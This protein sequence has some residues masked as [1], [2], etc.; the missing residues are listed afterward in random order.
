MTCT[1]DTRPKR[2]LSAKLAAGI[3]LSA[4]LALGTFVASAGAQPHRDDHRGGERHDDR[5]RGHWGGRDGGY[6]AAPP[7]IYG[8]PAYYPPPV[9]YGPAIGIYVPGVTIGI[10]Q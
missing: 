10:Q 1:I 7:V 4:V 2:H 3:A 5:G 6:Y 9:V 8:G